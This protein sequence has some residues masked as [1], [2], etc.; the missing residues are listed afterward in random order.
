VNPANLRLIRDVAQHRSVSKA[1]RWNDLS[2]SAASQALGEL[3][4]ELGVTLFD[5]GTRPL[6]V[7]PAGKAYVEFCRDVLRR[8]DEMLSLLDS[9]KKQLNATVRLAAIYSVGLSEMSSIEARFAE[10]FADAELQ[11]QYLRPERVWQAVAEDEADLGLMSYAESSRE[12]VALSWRDEEMVVAVP[13]DDPLAAYQAL[14]AS[15]LEGRLFVAFDEDLPIQ[16]HID[17]YM[18]EHEV[19]VEITLRFDNIEMIKQAVAHGAG[20]SIMPQRVMHEDMLQGRLIAL[21]LEPAELFRPVR[22]VH[23]RRKVFNEVTIGLLELLK[24]EEQLP[25]A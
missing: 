24:E 21:P 1:A 5:R 17:R 13:P 7:T 12:V 2:Q 3:E 16:Q 9:I 18:R 14:S 6:T 22:I 20:I 8:H 4:R 15:A 19:E 10:R 23:R 25:A 11:V